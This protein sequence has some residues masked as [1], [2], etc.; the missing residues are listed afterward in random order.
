MTSGTYPAKRFGEPGA[1]SAVISQPIATGPVGQLAAARAAERQAD[2]NAA[3]ALLSMHRWDLEK[4]CAMGD[5]SPKNTS[6]TK[7]QKAE[8]KAAS[9]PRSAPKK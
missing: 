3:D 9:A 4:G 5:K 6:K 2:L 8:K 1:G 7:K